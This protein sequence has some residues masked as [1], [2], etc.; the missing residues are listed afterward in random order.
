MMDRRKSGQPVKEVTPLKMDL[1]GI[2]EKLGGAQGIAG[3]TGSLIQGL[4]MLGNEKNNRQQTDQLMAL[5]SIVSQA[6]GIRPEPQQRKYVRPEDMVID[7]NQLHS[8]YG[9]GSNMLA[10]NGAK[11]PSYNPGGWITDI[12]GEGNEGNVGSLVGNL[13]GGGTGQQ[14]GAGKI[15]TFG[16]QNRLTCCIKFRIGH[17]LLHIPSRFRNQLQC[18]RALL[19]IVKNSLIKIFIICLHFPVSIETV[20]YGW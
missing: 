14:T 6:A 8:S 19:I 5:S 13:I 4:Q 12:T 17:I 20:I 15:V 16:K 18:T 11:L 7:P 9:T 3:T 1:G 2:I 10:K